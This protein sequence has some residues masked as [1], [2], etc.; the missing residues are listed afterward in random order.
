MMNLFQTFFG[1]MLTKI[2]KGTIGHL[3]EDIRVTY[4]LTEQYFPI[5]RGKA[6]QFSKI[7]K[8]HIV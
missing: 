2:H 6:V 1:H 7:S 5:K 4:Y 8:L 3:R